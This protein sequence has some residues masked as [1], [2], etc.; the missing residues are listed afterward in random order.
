MLVQVPM[1]GRLLCLAVVAGSATGCAGP[2]VRPGE[3]R[4]EPRLE[5]VPRARQVPLG[6]KLVKRAAAL[7]GVRSLSK[8]SRAVPDD[9]TGLVRLVYQG[10][11]IDLMNAPGGKPGENGVTAIYRRARAAGALH[12]RAP[13]PGDLVFFRETYDRN[14]D[15]RRND[16][17]THV[18]VVESVAKDGTVTF[19]H[20]GSAGVERSRLNLRTP[21]R[22]VDSHGRILNDYLR[23]RTGRTR[24]YLTGELFSGYGSPER[25]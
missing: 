21:R 2:R 11:G 1:M 5:V 10:E 14:R 4:T 16:G 24:A 12:R 23:R 17:L 15:G 25:L 20:R 8:V 19:I 18:G 9:C 7:V 6:E 22:R 3:A 13:R